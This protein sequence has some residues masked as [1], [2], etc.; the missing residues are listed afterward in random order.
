MR[1]RLSILAAVAVAGTSTPA[2]ASEVI[3]FDSDHTAYGGDYPTG[4]SLLFSGG[5]VNVR[6]SGWSI[7]DDGDIYKAQLGVWSNGLGV[8]NG[9]ND[10][11]HTI[12]NSGFLDFILLQFDQVVEL[13]NARFW[14]GW[15]GMNDTDATLGYATTD[16]SF[17]TPPA[18]H[19]LPQS[20]LA[21]LN[22]YGSGSWGNSGD[23]FRGINP[24]GSIGNLWLIGAAFDNPEG[25]YKRDG[26]KLDK[27]TFSLVPPSAVPEPSTWAMLLVGF[28]AIG[29]AMRSR[30]KPRVAVSFA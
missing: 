8:K 6:V 16:L 18:L 9:R 10:N 11:S 12:D 20:Q 25:W 3:W 22:L 21:G 19:G 26:F 13:E 24:D 23:S 14:T 27:L 2:I 7:H 5:G 4:T 1:K 15:H 17:A 29:A 30:R 28:G